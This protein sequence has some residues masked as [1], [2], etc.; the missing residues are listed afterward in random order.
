MSC[1]QSESRQ[2]LRA[3][4][5]D[6]DAGDLLQRTVVVCG[7]AD[8][9]GGVSVNLKQVRAV[10][11]NPV[12]AR[13]AGDGCIETSGRSIAWNSRARGILRDLQAP[14]VDT[15]RADVAVTEI[16]C[17]DHSVIRGNGDPT[18]L[19]RQACGRIDLHQRTDAEIPVAIDGSHRAPVADGISDDEGIR[20][21]VQEG[22][23]ERRT[24]LP[25]LERG[26][27]K[28]AVLVDGEYDDAV[29]IWRVG[30]NDLEAAI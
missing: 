8:E 10:R 23:V 20:L 7:V 5:G 29:G 25:V 1:M 21:A 11:R 2:A 13:S 14:A 24:R 27:P 17:V 16:R 19:R 30:S 9:F 12:V 28:R 15:K 3:V 18:Q 4:V 26:W 22:N 6:R